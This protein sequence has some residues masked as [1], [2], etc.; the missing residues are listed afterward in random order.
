MNSLVNA[1]DPPPTEQVATP[2]SPELPEH[3]T[4]ATET[5]VEHIRTA[6]LT[7]Q[8]LIELRECVST[9]LRAIHLRLGRLTELSVE[10]FEN[11]EA[12]VGR[13]E[14]PPSNEPASTQTLVGSSSE[15]TAEDSI[16]LS[17]ID[18]ITS[19]PEKDSQKTDDMKTPTRP[20]PL[21]LQTAPHRPDLDGTPYPPTTTRSAPP[22]NEQN[23][24][25][26]TPR[27]TRAAPKKSESYYFNVLNGKM[28]AHIP[29]FSGREVWELVRTQSVV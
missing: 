4:L 23:D 22:A 24:S 10:R 13:L 29:T 11:L 12:R 26:A 18:N 19:A 27:V 17:T 25:E 21:I 1:D 2:T 28:A 7:G 20:P 16:A 6:K 9:D 14:G 15:K 8:T 3:I 5:A